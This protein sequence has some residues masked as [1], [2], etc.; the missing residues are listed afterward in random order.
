[1][2]LAQAYSKHSHTRSTD[3]SRRV[4]RQRLFSDE[5][6]DDVSLDRKPSSDELD[7]DGTF[8]ERC[9]YLRSLVNNN[10]SI[11]AFFDKMTGSY[12]TD[13]QSLL[14]ESREASGFNSNDY[15]FNFFFKSIASES[16]FAKNKYRIADCGCGIFGF[17]P[18][19]RD[20]MSNAMRGVIP[21]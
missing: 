14:K 15:V 2:Y 8:Q 5:A 12:F 18:T 9:R 11:H 7:P 20:C 13:Y 19:V 17:G 6:S 10:D 1:M 21:R 4:L 3:L 16:E